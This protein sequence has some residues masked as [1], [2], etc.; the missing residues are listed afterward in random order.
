MSKRTWR[1]AQRALAYPH[2]T[3][4]E[5][6]DRQGRGLLAWL[7]TRV[8]QLRSICVPAL[9]LVGED[10]MLTPPDLSRALAKRLPG[11]RL[12]VLPGAHGFFP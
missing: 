11:A 10:D 7:G 9:V 5:A 6:I 12:V 3:K 2:Q 8:K 1:F 4:A